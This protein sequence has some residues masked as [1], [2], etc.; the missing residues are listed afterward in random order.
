MGLLEFLE[1]LVMG[2]GMRVRGEIKRIFLGFDLS[3]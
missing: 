3:N 1:G 2:E